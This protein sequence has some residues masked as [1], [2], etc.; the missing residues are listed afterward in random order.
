MRSDREIEAAHHQLG[1]L[2]RRDF[3][4]GLVGAGA[5]MA[6]SSSLVP[7]A[8]AHKSHAGLPQ[9]IAEAVKL[10]KTNKIS[11]TELISAY[12]QCANDLESTLNAF[13]TITGQEAL[14]RAAALDAQKGKKGPLHGIPL[15]FKDNID[16]A[17]IL[18]TRGSKFYENRVAT[19]D[20][21]VIRKLKEAG[22]VI[23][24]KANMNEFAAGVAGLNLNYG[25]AVNP[26][27]VNHWPGGSSSGSGVSVAA[28]ICLG[29][30]GTDT[31]VSIRGPASW[32][33]LV[34]VRPSYGRV[35]V[36]GTFPRAYTFDTVGPLAHTVED[37]ATILTAIAGFDPL[38]DFAVPSP[39]EDFTKH[40]KGKVK[41]LRLGIV[42]DFTFRNVDAEVAAAVRAAID[43]LED[44]GAEIKEVSIPLLSGKI[45]FQYP[46]TILLYEFNQILG[47][48]YDAEPDK[49]KFGPVVQAN[50][51]AGK[52][53]STQTYN[54]A[55]AR[56]PGEIAEIRE[57]FDE[58][59]AFIT[60]THPFVAPL[61]SVNAEGNAGVRQFTVP[62][63]YTGFPAISIPCGFNSEGLP[64]G[65]QIVANDFQEQL[66]FNIALAF[67]QA[68]DFHVQHPGI[69]CS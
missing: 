7:Q 19:V 55:I 61:T 14:A 30:L 66:L 46:L 44:L 4:R 23:L 6:L 26:W 27:N 59:D 41:K 62:I 53:I 56:R 3:L 17:G 37:A 68:T 45:D 63:S 12:L 9:T 35:S 5:T 13:I 33:G 49:T 22:A 29:S 15:V 40:L 57:V 69:Y 60:P 64:I 24:G 8:M 21:E 48:T 25:N 10:I 31:G 2:R 65:L 52:L 18:T 28:G 34:G 58:V 67:E 20:A 50:I 38:D 39:N 16:T 32:L 54:E 51:A 36:R 1:T 47:P 42:E 11:V 43:L